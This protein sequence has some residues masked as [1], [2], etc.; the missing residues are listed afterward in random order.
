MVTSR[1]AASARASSKATRERILKAALRLFRE[2]GFDRTTMRQIA[3]HSGMALGAAYYHFRSKDALVMAYYELAQEEL[4][5]QLAEALTPRKLAERLRALLEVKFRYFRPNRSL[6]GALSR[7]VDPRHPLSPFSSET[8][9]VREGDIAWFGR[10]LEGSA[11][12]VPSDLQPHLPRML[13]LYQMG[14]LLFWVYDGSPGQART[15][16]LVEKS[17]AMVVFLIKLSGLPILRPL[18]KGVLDLV[19]TV[20]GDGGSLGA[21]VRL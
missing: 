6:L 12:R 11:E 16:R 4:R 14:L 21:E 9:R 15:E 7:H 17:L 2:Q 19:L 3:G 20:W 5:P 13:W 10:V 18:R 1:S 8:R